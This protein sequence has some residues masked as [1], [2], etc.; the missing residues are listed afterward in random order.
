M[1]LLRC[2][3]HRR[4][5]VALGRL[6]PLF[7][8]RC[9]VHAGLEFWSG[10]RPSVAGWRW[11]PG[12]APR[13]WHIHEM[14]FG[15]MSAVVTGF[16]FTAI[17]NWTGRLPIRGLPLLGLVVLWIAGRICLTFSAYTGWLVAMLVDVRFPDS[18]RCRYNPR[19]R[20]GPQLAQS[21]GGRH[22]RLPA[23][24]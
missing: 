24:R 3:F 11:P 5:A 2:S 18:G 8:A 20:G 23:A 19:D 6:P 22:R 21:A 15:F 17:P 7:P 1:T 12:F 16:L 14:L 9:V 10:C 13:D 4:L